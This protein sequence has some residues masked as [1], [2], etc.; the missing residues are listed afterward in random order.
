MGER[1]VEAIVIGPGS[2]GHLRIRVGQRERDVPAE[3][4]P[5]ELRTPNSEFVA[6]VQGGDL[7]RVEVAGRPWLVIQNRVR[8]VLNSNWDPIGV[9]TEVADEYD[10]Y[11]SSI[12]SMLRRNASPKEIA[13]RLLKIET[14]SMGLDGSPES[15]R[16]EV[17]NQLLALDL[18]SP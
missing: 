15:Q 1:R 11:I 10:G 14:D 17:A 13:A 8:T 9:A 18:P 6:V 16:L 7:L 4:V 2:P 12:Y 5:P 3:R